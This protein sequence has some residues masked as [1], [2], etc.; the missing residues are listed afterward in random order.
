[1]DNIIELVPHD[2]QLGNVIGQNCNRVQLHNSI[3]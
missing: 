3:N 1:M 2:N